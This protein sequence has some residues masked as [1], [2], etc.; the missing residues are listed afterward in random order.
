MDFEDCLKTMAREGGSDLYLTTGAPPSA[1]FNGELRPLSS[2]VLSPDRT[3]EFA[4][5]L[6]D[7]QQ[8]PVVGELPLG[9]G[10]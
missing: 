4:H 2:A 7:D 8:R 9:S 1:K 5:Q 3:K 6:M 10:V